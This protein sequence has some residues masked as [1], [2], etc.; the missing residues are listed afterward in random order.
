MQQEPNFKDQ[1]N[2]RGRIKNPLTTSSLLKHM[3]ATNLGGCEWQAYERNLA[4][5][6]PKK[7]ICRIIPE[8]FRTFKLKKNWL[9]VYVQC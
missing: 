7:G 2:S 9:I 4:E 1:K 8:T 6:N 3:T 5:V